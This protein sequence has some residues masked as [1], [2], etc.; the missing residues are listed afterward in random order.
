MWTDIKQ[1]AVG[2]TTFGKPILDESTFSLF[3]LKNAEPFTINEH[4]N[5]GI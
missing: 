4:N 2:K 5:N 3:L 1:T